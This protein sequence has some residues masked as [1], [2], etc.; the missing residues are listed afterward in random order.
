MSRLMPWPGRY[1]VSPGS[2]PSLYAPL[3]CMVAATDCNCSHWVGFLPAHFVAWADTKP[4]SVGSSVEVPNDW[5]SEGTSL[6]ATCV[7][8][9][10]SPAESRLGTMACPVSVL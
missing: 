8:V 6:T 10:T 3:P 9:T 1:W 2:V 7:D 5:K 4:Y